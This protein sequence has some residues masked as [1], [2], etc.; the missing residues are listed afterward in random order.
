MSYYIKLEI[1]KVVIKTTRACM[2][3][4]KDFMSEGNHNRMC[5]SCKVYARDHDHPFTPLSEGDV[6]GMIAG[7]TTG[8]GVQRGRR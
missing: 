8:H 7:R 4:R 3:C 2:C 5:V 6:T 1:N